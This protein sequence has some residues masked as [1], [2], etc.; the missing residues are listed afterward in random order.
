MD[1]GQTL[2]R[3]QLYFRWQS[4]GFRGRRG[5]LWAATDLPALGH[6]A[7]VAGRRCNEAG[8]IPGDAM[9]PAECSLCE[10]HGEE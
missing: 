2:G 4:L 8:V 9:L 6:H 10:E 1:S 7:V 3:Q 5:E